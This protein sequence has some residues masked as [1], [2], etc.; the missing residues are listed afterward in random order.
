M[1]Q[2]ILIPD[3]GRKT[4]PQS[5]GLGVPVDKDIRIIKIPAAKEGSSE[6]K[7]FPIN[8]WTMPPQQDGYLKSNHKDCL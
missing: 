5:S 7:D 6:K 4:R 2:E 8:T 3:K 1:A